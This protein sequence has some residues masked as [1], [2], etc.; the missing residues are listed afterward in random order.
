MCTVVLIICVIIASLTGCNKTLSVKPVSGEISE[1][2]IKNYLDKNYSSLNVSDDKNYSSFSLLNNELNNNQVF[3][4]GSIAGTKTNEDIGTKLLKYFKESAGVRYYI[5]DIPYSLAGLLNEYLAS[6]DDKILDDTFKSVKGTMLWNKADY[7]KWKKIYEYNKSLSKNEKII[8]IGIDAEFGGGTV[9][10]FMHSFVPNTAAPSK[11]QPV[12]KE[13]NDLYTSPT[14]NDKTIKDFSTDLKKSIDENTDVYKGY[15]GDSFFDLEFI[16]DN[17][18]AGFE[19]ANAYSKGENEFNKVRNKIL[20]DNFKKLYSR[21]QNTG[22]FYGELQ[23]NPGEI[24]QKTHKN[25]DYFGALINSKDSPVKGK[26]LSIMPLYK[27]C[28]F[29]VQTQNGKYSRRTISNYAS[30]D[31]P[32][33]PFI[34]DDITL[35]RL[36]GDASPFQKDLIWPDNYF[37]PGTRR[38]SETTTDYYQY[39]VVIKNSKAVE[40][41]EQ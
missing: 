10:K 36:K 28:D 19:I 22:K 34:D 30:I 40:S 2:S 35:F 23:S 12:M 41:L 16:N 24:F 7:D 29:M 25:I 1:V 6:G 5:Q 9:F 3:L 39:A 14:N 31:N 4:L 8:V 32:L 15:F 20:Y 18:L 26:I 17:I 33:D 37:D 21:I 27:N 38:G 13:L 11:I